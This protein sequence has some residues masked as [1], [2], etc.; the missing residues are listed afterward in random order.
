[1]ALYFYQAYTK[2][3]KKVSGHLDAPT[4]SRVKEQ[5]GAQ[6]LYPIAIE[7]TQEQAR[8][9]F[10][11]RLFTRG[12][13]TKEK[14]LFTKQLA[15]LLKS[16]VPVLPAFELLIDQFEGGMHSILVV[17]K[18]DLKEGQSL[19]DSLKKYP[20][21]F[22]TIYIQLVRAGEASGR[23]EIILERLTQYLERREQVRKKI[24]GALQYPMMQL[25]V[26]V[27]IFVWS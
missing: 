27:G 25:F 15:V 18:D 23:L 24:A 19:A 1:M 5:L 7:L 16:G 20:K 3:G 8:Q 10:I 26:A 9:N 2:D 14:I 4:A 13:S 6:G 11:K 21:V 22:E 12:V 17:V